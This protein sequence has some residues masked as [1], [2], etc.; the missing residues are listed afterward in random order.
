MYTN[1]TYLAN[2]E[3]RVTDRSINLIGVT[4][5]AL[6]LIA[7]VVTTVALS[8]EDHPNEVPTVGPGIIIGGILAILAPSV[9][10]PIATSFI[11]DGFSK[12]VSLLKSKIEIGV[13]LDSS[14]KTTNQ[15]KRKTKK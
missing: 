14:D 3:K 15:S 12:F 2:Y 10:S 6:G 1:T 4:T 9:I 7:A 5:A 13:S 11:E 8:L